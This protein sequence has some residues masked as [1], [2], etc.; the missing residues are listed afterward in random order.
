M[1][2]KVEFEARTIGLFELHSEIIQ[3]GYFREYIF[4][5]F[6]ELPVE[7]LAAKASPEVAGDNSVRVEHRHDIERKVRPKQLGYRIV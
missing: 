4:V 7:I 1:K 2:V 6:F 3:R 5:E